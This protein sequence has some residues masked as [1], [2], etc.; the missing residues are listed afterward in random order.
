MGF[1]MINQ[2]RMVRYYYWMQE[3]QSKLTRS[4][5]IQVFDNVPHQCLLHAFSG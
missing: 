1:Q 3:Y 4:V 5:I 2:N